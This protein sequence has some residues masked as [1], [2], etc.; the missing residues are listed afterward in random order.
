VKIKDEPG[1]E[2]STAA[3]TGARA[4]ASP[5]ADPAAAGTEDAAAAEPNALAITLDL[6]VPSDG[7]ERA[8]FGGASTTESGSEEWEDVEPEPAGGGGGGSSG[9]AA[10]EDAAKNAGGWRERMAQRQQF[11]STSHGF[12]MGRKLGEWGAGEEEEE[13][14]PEAVAGGSLVAAGTG[15]GS[16]AA[17]A[18]AEEALLQEAIRRSLQDA[19][20]WLKP[21]CCTLSMHPAS[22]RVHLQQAM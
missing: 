3:S 12:K 8:L 4:G 7:V 15:G 21:A 11:W 2:P 14:A 19:G 20:V 10:T 6:A 18:E 13:E 16:A 17:G 9:P 1:T 5:A 22:R